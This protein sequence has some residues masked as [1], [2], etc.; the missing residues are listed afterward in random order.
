MRLLFLALVG[1]LAVPASAQQQ[2]TATPD[3]FLDNVTADN[4]VFV[5][6]DYLTGFEP[7]IRSMDLSAYH[8]NLT[9]LSRMVNVF[10][11][12]VIV[13]G[14]EGKGRGRF[15]R[16]MDEHFADAPRV[17]RDT[18]SAWREPAFVR[19][20]E[21][22]G[23]RKLVFAGISIDNCTLLTAL[24]AMRDGYEVY[25]VADVSGAESALIEDVALMR[26]VRA[27]AVP[28]TWVSLGSELLVSKGGWGTPEGAALA[29]VYSQHSNYL[30]TLQDAD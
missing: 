22:T 16:Q 21:A 24:D 8:N 23:R 4:A 7:A 13:L 28:V 12:P 30:R 27:G 29:Q 6:V 18:P 19:A 20:V 15:M 17:A 9:G 11:L 25:V 14:D 3:L 2:G 26:L 5:A 1:A 10:D